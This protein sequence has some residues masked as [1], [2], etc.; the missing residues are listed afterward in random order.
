M[1]RGRLAAT[2]AWVTAVCAAGAVGLLAGRAAFM[3]PEVDRTP[4]AVTTS[5]VVEATVGRTATYVAHA[6]WPGVDLLGAV[7]GTVTTIDID[8]GQ[9]VGPG[10]V[11]LTVGLRPVVIA[12]GEVPSFRDLGEGAH[13]ADVA[14]LQQLLVDSGH[15]TGPVD[16]RFAARTTRAVQRWQRDLGVERTATVAVGDV[17]YV[18]ELPARVVLGDEVRVGALLDAGAVVARAL[19]AAP[20]I[21]LTAGGSSDVPPIGTP[22]RVTSADHT[23]AGVV[24]ELR[25]PPDGTTETTAVLRSPEDG[26]LCG[27]ECD[28]VPLDDTG[29]LVAHVEVVAPATGA[30]VPVAALGTAA[31]GSVFVLD[32]AGSRRPVTV[33]ATDGSRAVVGGVAVGDVIRLFA[34]EESAGPDA[35]P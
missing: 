1:R 11:L 34:G 27:T 22:V 18:P 24:A 32:E 17:L 35:T 5:T 3:P 21:T 6:S 15:L 29:S 25:P 28:A 12:R 2:A 20:E 30:A 4:S 9:E 19:G 23:W 10:T 14:Q 33:L 7:S 26:P 31:D 8:P 16:G 13:G